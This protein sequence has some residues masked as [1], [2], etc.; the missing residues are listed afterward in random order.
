MSQYLVQRFVW[1]IIT[2]FLATLLIF[3]IIQLSPGDFV[4][5]IVSQTDTTGGLSSAATKLREYY[6]LDK[7]IY[8]QYFQWL[9]KIL[10]GDFG[11]SFLYRKPVIEVMRS[12]ILWTLVIT[13]LSFTFAWVVG[14]VIGIYSALHKYSVGDY[15]FTALGF[16]GL[17]SPS[18][19]IAMVIIYILISAGTGISGGLFSEKFVAAPWS[20]A[21]FI[22]LLKHL[23]IPI[24]VISISNMAEV[25]RIMRGSLLEVLN[26]PYIQAARAKGLSERVIVMKHALRNA[27]N[28]L[29]SLIGMSA[30]KLIAGIVQT[31]VVLNLPVVGPTYLV[32]LMSQD[33]YLAGAYL[34]LTVIL[35]LVGN[36]IADLALA[37]IDPRI[38]YD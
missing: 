1:M 19:F 27:I 17:S 33:V 11:Y 30:P 6:G 23:W 35:L 20:W 21:K 7:P 8:Q 14:S 22:D 13:I 4:T 37:W 28:P 12:E 38:R 15:I 2:F 18:F 16:L 32:A 31:A 9:Y 29:I 5:Y 24:V 25:I 3:T 34:L 26:Q 10:R 36:F